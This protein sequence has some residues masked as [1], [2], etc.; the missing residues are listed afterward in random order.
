MSYYPFQSED[1]P[2]PAFGGYSPL[3]P[4]TG[5]HVHLAIV[6]IVLYDKI[7]SIASEKHISYRLQV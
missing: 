4:E 1:L 7:H 6:S 3:A 2:W 5:T